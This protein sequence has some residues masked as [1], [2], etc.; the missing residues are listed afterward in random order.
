MRV[1]LFR[2]GEPW[3]GEVLRVEEFPV[4]LIEDD[5]GVVRPGQS[6]EGIPLCVLDEQHGNLVLLPQALSE[7]L[8]INE[9][10]VESGGLKPGDILSAG[11]RQFMVSYE[12][13]TSHPLPPRRFRILEPLAT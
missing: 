3:I 10:V 5:K 1:R 11:E 2:L 7:L 12:R 6:G 13:T 8:S 4:L 9:S